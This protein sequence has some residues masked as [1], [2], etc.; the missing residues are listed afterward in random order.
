[1]IQLR[2]VAKD[3]VGGNPNEQFPLVEEF[4]NI[5]DLHRLA[6]SSGLEWRRAAN[7]YGGQYVDPTSGEEYIIV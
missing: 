7:I 6:K 5:M 4:V 3:K 1:M 2:K